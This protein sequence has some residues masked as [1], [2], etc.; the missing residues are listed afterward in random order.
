M[1]YICYDKNIISSRIFNQTHDSCVVFVVYR[2]KKNLISSVYHEWTIINSLSNKKI[3][4]QFI[5]FPVK[6]DALVLYLSVCLLQNVL[7]PGKRCIQPIF[8]PLTGAR[9]LFPP[10]EPNYNKHMICCNLIT[11]SQSMFWLKARWA[12]A[13]SWSM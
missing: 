2:K 12:V 7:H 11:C 1:A 10:N 6:I 3:R 4:S 13:R 9:V 8:F 5:I